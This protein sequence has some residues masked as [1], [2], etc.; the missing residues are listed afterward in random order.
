MRNRRISNEKLKQMRSYLPHGSNSIIAK[1]TGLTQE[2]VSK[3]LHGV[4]SNYSVI[5]EALNIALEEKT[6]SDALNTLLDG[7]FK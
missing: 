2:Y 1:K 5:N 4:Y 7:S 3:V 6:K